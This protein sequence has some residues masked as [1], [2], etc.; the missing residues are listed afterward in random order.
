MK[1]PKTKQREVARI[2]HYAYCPYCEK[3]GLPLKD[4][5]IKGNSVSQVYYALDTHIKQ[6][7][8][9]IKWKK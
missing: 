1:K 9:K 6:K 7:H 3:A 5:E 4:C 2:Q 8:K